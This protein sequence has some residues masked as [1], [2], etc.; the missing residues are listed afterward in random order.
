MKYS[1]QD[2][3]EIDA[4]LMKLVPEARKRLNAAIASKNPLVLA[5]A[6]EY[7]K[8]LDVKLQV[9]TLRKDSCFHLYG[10]TVSDLLSFLLISRYRKCVR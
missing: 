3:D 7:A 4:K 10:L 5:E 8:S 2:L 9:N 6:V 1:L